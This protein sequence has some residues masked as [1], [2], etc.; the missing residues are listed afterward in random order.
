MEA[1]FCS[2]SY[3]DYESPEFF[4]LRMVKARKQHQCCECGEPTQPGDTYEHITGKW[5][6]EI[7]RYRTCLTCS[8]IRSDYCAGLTKLRETIWEGLGVDYMGEW[9]DD[10]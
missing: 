5:C 10:D 1:G 3:D 7:G 4:S 9:D 2:C 6:G 8:R